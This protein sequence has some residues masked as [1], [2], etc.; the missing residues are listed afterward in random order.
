MFYYLLGNIHPR[1]R[2]RLNTIQLLCVVKSTYINEYGM[3]E[4]LRPFVG[5]VMKL[6]KVCA[7]SI[8]WKVISPKLICPG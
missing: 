4:I 1:L 2:A 7:L 5:D 8:T 3:D 6:E